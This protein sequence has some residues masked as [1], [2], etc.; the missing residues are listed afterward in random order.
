MKTLKRTRTKQRRGTDRSGSVIVVVMALLGSLMIMGFFLFSLAQQEREN[1]EYFKQAS[2]DLQPIQLDPNDIFD[3]YLRQLILGAAPYEYQSAFWGGRI[4]LLPTMFGPDINP[5]SGEGVNA[6][7]YNNTT[8]PALSGP[9]PDMNYN[10]VPDPIAP[11][12]GD[13]IPNNY[14]LDVNQSPGAQGQRHDLYG[15]N[16]GHQTPHPDV[17]YTAADHNFPM[18]TYV[19]QVPLVNSSGIVQNVIPVVLPAAHRPQ[20]LEGTGV[21]PGAWYFDPSTATRVLRPHQE[22]FAVN[23]NGVVMNGASA[24]LVYRFVSGAHPD[25]SGAGVAPFPLAVTSEG[26]W[27]N[28]PGVAPQYDADPTGRGWNDAVYMDIGFPMQTDPV[29]G[30]NYVPLVAATILDGESMVNVNTGGN[31][32]RLT[33][34]SQ[35]R[36]GAFAL[37]G[38]APFAYLRPGGFIYS[39]SGSNHGVTRS[40]VNP[41][42]VLN[43][44]PNDI[45][46]GGDYA[47]APGTLNAAL[48]QYRMMFGRNPADNTNDPMYRFME[49]SNMDLFNLLHGRASFSSGSP[50]PASAANI[51]ETYPG[52]WTGT[53]SNEASRLNAAINSRLLAAFPW[54]GRSYGAA[55]VVDDNLNRFAGGQGAL[56]SFFRQVDLSTQ[57]ALNYGFPGGLESFFHPLDFNG[58]GADRATGSTTP[59]SRVFVPPAVA[60]QL[61]QV[62]FVQYSDYL[63]DNL[64]GYQ[65]VGANFNPIL[66]FMPTKT[67]NYLD[68]DARET[69]QDPTKAQNQL[70]DSIFSAGDSSGLQLTRL[71]LT[72]TGTASRF[73]NLM[74]FNASIS[75]REQQIRQKLTTRSNDLKGYMKSWYQNNTNPQLRKWEVQPIFP[76]QYPGAGLSYAPGSAA[77]SLEPEPTNDPFRSALRELLTMR[78]AQTNFRY[79]MRKLSV[80]HV[81][82]RNP[83]NGYLRF[84]QLT[85]HPPGLGAGQISTVAYYPEQV[86]NVQQQEFLARYDRQKLARDIYVLLYTFC[87][88]QDNNTVLTSGSAYTAEQLREMAQFAVNVVDQM[89]GD[90]VITRFEYDA[91]LSNGWGLDDNAYTTNDS[92]AGSDRREVYGVEEQFLTLSEALAIYAP[93]HKDNNGQPADTTVTEYD[94]SKTANFMF[95]EL[96]NMSPRGVAFN[97]GGWQIIVRSPSESATPTLTEHK[98]TL[99]ND[100]VAPTARYTIGTLNATSKLKPGTLDMDGDGKDG[101]TRLRVD[102]KAGKNYVRIAPR[103]DADSSDVTKTVDLD[104]IRQGDGSKYRFDDAAGTSGRPGKNL[105]QFTT[106]TTPAAG[107]KIEII[108]RRRANLSRVLPG[109]DADYDNPWVVA[110]RLRIDVALFQLQQGNPQASNIQQQLDKQN[111]WLRIQ[112]LFGIPMSGANKGTVEYD[113]ATVSNIL[114][115]EPTSSG[116]PPFDEYRQNTLCQRNVPID[117]TQPPLGSYNLWQPHY[118]RDFASTAELLNVGTYG[119]QTLNVTGTAGMPKT[120]YAQIPET[121]FQLGGILGDVPGTSPSATMGAWAATLIGQN[122]FG[123]KALYPDNRTPMNNM[124]DFPNRWY[125]L[126]E[127]VEVPSRQDLAGFGE[128]LG[129]NLNGYQTTDVRDFGP[130]NPNTISSPELLGALLD[131]P[132]AMMLTGVQAQLPELRDRA[133]YTLGDSRRDWW[134]TFLYTRDGAQAFAPGIITPGNPTAAQ[135]L[136]LPGIPGI[137]RPFR[138][139][140]N[141]GNVPLSGEQPKTSAPLGP[142]HDGMQNTVLRNMLVPSGSISPKLNRDQRALFEIGTRAQH[143]SAAI[144]ATLKYKTLGKVLNNA[145]TTSNTFHVFLQIDYFAATQVAPGVVRVGAKLP[146]SPALRGYFVIDRGKALEMVGPNDAGPKVDPNNPAVRVFSFSQDFNW[147]ALVLHRQRL[148]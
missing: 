147:E 115:P 42:W 39:I 92:S 119:P 148:N 11:T 79:L 111:S 69:L 141:T 19:S 25:T 135:I 18:L 28:A 96:Q 55:A 82:D 89:D 73:D 99:M 54:A 36:A 94:D 104:L 2:K 78:P 65:S 83:A 81:L 49:M 131:E 93:I 144:D 113:D 1:A 56:P 98:V 10:G 51:I 129:R 125:R 3:S 142:D 59:Y 43:S 30:Q 33:A 16:T 100:T 26:V 77:Y 47:G 52:R 40:E 9:Y 5:Y 6:V 90:D 137:S 97:E 46:V 20:L 110:D 107:T 108:L 72:A 64:V 66:T 134:Q 75:N 37:G 17:D 62:S 21:P 12:Q 27:A 106:G 29:T 132:D 133:G 91:N 68:N 44:I 70:T 112:P 84:R 103:G 140:A 80:N 102:P 60:N 63:V 146:T 45:G 122:T 121:T 143:N 32:F 127:F 85:P 76:P 14:L 53:D 145:V 139:L 126:L 48:E 136:P 128:L 35:G 86:G 58:M 117:Y 31:D 118:N 101:P 7:W 124:D 4:S 74:P 130:I 41:S 116:S 38:T 88:A 114:G 13:G 138:S 123:W 71:D 120:P 8:N 50:V 15:T 23:S 109:D 67:V 61:N 95:V 57:V 105:L 24:P 87:G 22:H 34:G